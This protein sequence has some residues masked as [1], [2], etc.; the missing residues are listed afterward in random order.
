MRLSVLFFFFFVNFRVKI[1]GSREMR[2]YILSLNLSPK[3]VVFNLSYLLGLFYWHFWARRVKLCRT[4]LHFH[5]HF[6][7][8]GPCP[9]WTFS[10]VGPKRPDPT[11]KQAAMTSWVLRHH[12]ASYL[13]F[14]P[15]LENKSH[16]LQDSCFAHSEQISPSGQLQQLVQLLLSL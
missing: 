8:A 5:Y 2:P 7:C 1:R 9:R 3:S 10:G 13:P 12:S 15:C 4:D 11:S 16:T 14:S 6:F